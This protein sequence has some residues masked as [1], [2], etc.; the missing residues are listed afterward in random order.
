M[1]FKHCG[2]GEYT[3]I[4]NNTLDK[5]NL[6][7]GLWNGVFEDREDTWLRWFDANNNLILT[8]AEHAKLEKQRA[9]SE[10]QRAKEEKQRADT[11]QRTAEEERQRADSEQ[12]RAE[13]LAKRLKE[14]GID[15][16]TLS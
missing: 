11:A 8:G 5:L 9:D 14:L 12:R 13:I 2:L 6:K 16:D 1:V 3:Q 10:K 4:K 15:P 7:I